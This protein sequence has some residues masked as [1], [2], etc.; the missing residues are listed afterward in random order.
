MCLLVDSLQT[1]SQNLSVGVGAVLN[2]R[3]KDLHGV[4]LFALL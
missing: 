1:W 4:H 2:L 3:G